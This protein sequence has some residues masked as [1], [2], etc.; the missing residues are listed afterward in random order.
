M[1]IRVGLNHPSC[2]KTSHLFTALFL[3]LGMGWAREARAEFSKEICL[4]SHIIQTSRFFEIICQSSYEL[5]R[6]KSLLLECLGTS[7]S[8][9]RSCLKQRPFLKKR[10]K[11]NWEIVAFHSCKTIPLFYVPSYIHYKLEKKL[12][13][14]F[15]KVDLFCLFLK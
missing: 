2:H 12:T 15:L 14:N 5:Y 8:V 1:P 9:A 11:K 3:V 4:S 6:M 13:M 10:C 7:P